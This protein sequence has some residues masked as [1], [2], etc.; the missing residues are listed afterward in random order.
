MAVRGDRNKE[1]AWWRNSDKNDEDDSLLF[2]LLVG[3][4]RGKL[5]V[6]EG[7]HL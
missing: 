7:Y 5:V 3:L 1:A 4:P 6:W 2:D